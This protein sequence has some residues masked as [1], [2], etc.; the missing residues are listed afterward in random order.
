MTTHQDS[1][2]VEAMEAPPEASPDAAIQAARMKTENARL[3]GELRQGLMRAER[4]ERQLERVQASAKYQVGDLLVQAAKHPARLFLLPRDLWRIYSLRRARRRQPKPTTAAPLQRA[5]RDELLDLEAA[6]LLLPRTA[7]APAASFAI[8]GALSRA[9]AEAWAPYAAVTTL[10]PHDAAELVL[11]VDADVVVI[12]SAA[13]LPGEMWSYLGD[14]S[15]SDRER[16][17]L[18]LVDAA[19]ERGRSVVFLRNTPP[20]HTV[21]LDE[22]AAR[23]DL[24]VDGPGSVRR[25]PWH[26]GIDPFAWGSFGAPDR[27]GVVLLGWPDDLR[28]GPQERA[29]VAAITS[30]LAAT[31]THAVDPRRPAGATTRRALRAA[32]AGVAFPLTVSASRMGAAPSKLQILAAGLP[33]VSG[34]DQDLESSIS[35][36][37]HLVH[38][39]SEA[40]L[41]VA[42]TQAP[43][44]GDQQQALR[45]ELTVVYGAPVRLQDLAERLHLPSRPLAAWD[46][47]MVCQGDIPVDDIL[48]QTWRPQEIVV[49]TPISD[50]T[51]DAL[52]GVTVTSLL[53]T[54]LSSPEAQR[55]ASRNRHIVSDVNLSHSDALL[56]LLIDSAS[57]RPAMVGAS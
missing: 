23:C 27:S 11:D 19:H 46:I 35:S 57:V 45:R 14:P 37:V 31:V 10:L 54:D 17:A 51:R 56:D 41:A 2:P 12:E 5:R 32:T 7:A 43:L 38:D 28:S 55:M 8:A 34:P 4:A 47:T 44:T 33:L 21:F 26:P 48:R 42:A 30:A 29:L 39:P 50:V 52:P 20:S 16:Q 1:T 25:E 40:P 9:T 24:V 3:R 15:A 49:N 22:L 53:G 6:R 36:G 18:R 13:A